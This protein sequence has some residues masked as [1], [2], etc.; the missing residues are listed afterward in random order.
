MC[1]HRVH[2]FVQPFIELKKAE[3][4]TVGCNGQIFVCGFCFVFFL[5]F[6]IGITVMLTAAVAVEMVV[7]ALLMILIFVGLLYTLI[8]F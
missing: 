7:V 4:F 6:R 8:L 1:V 5:A 2:L 3:K